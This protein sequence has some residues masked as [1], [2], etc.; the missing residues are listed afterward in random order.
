MPWYWIGYSVA[1]DQ[2]RQPGYGGIEWEMPTIPR[3]AGEVMALSADITR[4][5]HRRKSL[6]QDRRVLVLSWSEMGE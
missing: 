2:G 1:D 6:E 3:N 5:L 4:E